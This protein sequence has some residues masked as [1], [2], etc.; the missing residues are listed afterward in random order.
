M[1]QDVLTAFFGWMTILNFGLLLVAG[2]S[3]I[4][5]RDWAADLHARLFGIEK[6]DVQNVYFRWL[7]LYK[8]F[9]LIFCVMP[10]I[11]LRLI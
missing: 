8:L 9:I 6:Q 7:A 1:S 11:A 10:Y 5:L 4:A 3:L 2:I